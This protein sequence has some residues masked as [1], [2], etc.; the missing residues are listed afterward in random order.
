MPLGLEVFS[1]LSFPLFKWEC[2]PS[3]TDW[4]MHSHAQHGSHT[5][6]NNKLHLLEIGILN[7]KN[8]PIKTFQFDD[9]IKGFY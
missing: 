4:S 2:I 7:R 1:A 5:K 3:C 8:T 9:M 6:M